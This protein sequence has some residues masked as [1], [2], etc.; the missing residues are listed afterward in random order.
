MDVLR[1]LRALAAV[2][3][4]LCV[5]QRSSLAFPVKKVSSLRHS[6]LYR[7]TGG[8]RT[9]FDKAYAPSYHFRKPPPPSY[10]LP[11]PPNPHAASKEAERLGKLHQNI[12]I[13]QL[14]VA[15]APEV[16]E[17]DRVKVKHAVSF[18][19]I[20]ESLCRHCSVS[21]CFCLSLCCW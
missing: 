4:V 21:V 3:L 10:K 12:T 7:Q 5:L 16:K 6:R 14:K 11:P 13:R 17:F 2:C 9:L 19:N 8:K 15:A 20:T 18:A 1:S